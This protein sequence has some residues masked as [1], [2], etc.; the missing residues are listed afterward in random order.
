MD[1]D[2]QGAPSYTEYSVE[3]LFFQFNWVKHQSQAKF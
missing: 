1:I 2:E 3:R